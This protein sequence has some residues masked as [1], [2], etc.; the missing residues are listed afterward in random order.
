M[1]AGAL[2]YVMCFCFC[3]CHDRVTKENSTST[4]VEQLLES[5]SMTASVLR[6]NAL[7]DALIHVGCF[8]L[9]AAMVV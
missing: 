5:G 7:A 2:H 8:I 1:L 9:A 4:V 6:K 3:L